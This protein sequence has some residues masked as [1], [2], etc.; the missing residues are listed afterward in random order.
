MVIKVL[1]NL[2]RI[3][4]KHGENFNKEIENTTK[5]QIENTLQGFNSRM[6]EVGT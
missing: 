3:L 5:C 4:D 2:K 6:D 1:T